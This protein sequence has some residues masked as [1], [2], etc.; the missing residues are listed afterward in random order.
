MAVAFVIVLLAV[1]ASARRQLGDD[2]VKLPPADEFTRRVDKAAVSLS[3]GLSCHARDGLDLSGDVR[4][5]WIITAGAAE[6][7]LQNKQ[8][9][10]IAPFAV[11][12]GYPN[13]T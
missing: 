12:C 1:A 4:D 8:P 3:D 9:V 6:I 13:G 11:I 2:L 7:L 10:L 5:Y